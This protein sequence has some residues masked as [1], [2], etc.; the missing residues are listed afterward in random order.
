MN[1]VIFYSIFYL[2]CLISVFNPINTKAQDLSFAEDKNTYE[3]RNYAPH[4]WE[5]PKPKKPKGLIESNSELAKLYLVPK[6]I[7][8]LYPDEQINNNIT[9]VLQLIYPTTDIEKLETFGEYIKVYI[10]WKRRY[11]YVIK[12]L[13][14]K[15]RAIGILP[16][17]APIIAES[18]EFAPKYSDKTK[19]TSANEYQITYNPYKYLEYDQGEY[20]EPVRMRDKNY[21]KEPEN[22]DKILL[23]LLKFDIG[24]FVKEINKTVH[25]N[26]GS[27]EKP[28]ESDK[29][30]KARILLAKSE[31]GTD[32]KLKAVIDV[33]VP[34][35]YYIKGD[36]LNPNTKPHFF[37][38]EDMENAPNIKEYKLFLPEAD[39][40]VV[41]STAKKMHVGRVRFPLEI[42]RADI[43]KPTK[44]HGVFNFV[45]CSK[46]EN[47]QPLSTEHEI[48]IEPSL[49][50]R[51]S[52]FYNYVTQ[53]FTH[54]PHETAKHAKLKQIIFDEAQ[55]K[56]TVTFDTTKKFSQVAVMAED[57]IGTN[58]IKP[59]YSIDNNKVTAEFDVV[60]SK[61][62]Y[63]TS[64]TTDIAVTAS[65]NSDETMRT[66]TS[67]IYITPSKSQNNKATFWP[68]YIFGL[69]LNLMPVIFY[70]FIRLI[71][72][73]KEQKE[74]TK[75]LLRYI[76]GTALGLILTGIFFQNKYLSEMYENSWLL[77]TA[78]IIATSFFM[79]TLCYMDFALFRPLK[80]VMRRGWII[81]LFSIILMLAFP[82]FLK[83]DILSTTF[84]SSLSQI[85]KTLFAIWLGIITL[86]I[87]VYLHNKQYPRWLNGFQKANT[88]YNF[89][90]II[91]IIWLIGAHRGEIAGMI[92]LVGFALVAALWYM[93]PLIV[94][95][96]VRH[97]R[98]TKNKI[99]LFAI[100]QKYTAFIVLFIWLVLCISITMFPLKSET[101]S[102]KPADIK[103]QIT[104]FP[105]ENKPILI[106][107]EADWSLI[108]IINRVTL[109]K[110]QQSDLEIIRINANG[111]AL[112]ARPWLIEYNKTH[113]PVNILFTRRHQKGLTLP[114]LINKID[115]RK[116]LEEFNTTT[117]ANERIKTND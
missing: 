60:P 97:V 24:T 4:D 44:I 32:D 71:R 14:Q 103:Q 28:V 61:N 41:N 102:I 40:V 52:V 87:L 99:S 89:I 68:A 1:K 84:E 75:I 98:S 57:A 46:D 83:A 105:L 74:K 26:D 53:G 15:I 25:M 69:L 54:L 85:Y 9:P 13:E 43:N 23:A 70:L 30:L 107:I 92:T 37:L 82:M 42:T 39:G 3:I 109:L 114:P 8:K 96:T 5:A 80:G 90:Y 33:Y 35:G 7:D 10:S 78:G 108:S 31:P 62:Q 16:K 38:K 116:A 36:Y 64:N 45:L 66:V 48:T 2:G 67:P 110:M 27:G 81:G 95:E 34:R 104:N 47:C 58:F 19:Q 113:A 12:Q 17:D 22:L 112:T 93:Y 72:L 77:V 88:V 91:G 106:V 21:E 20:G 11:D 56:L 63:S 111:K 29:G 86:P 55:K 94:T 76:S 51:Y 65:F 18:G 117:P 49:E 73:L 79:E 6:L 59:R 101:S 50:E 100:I 115:W